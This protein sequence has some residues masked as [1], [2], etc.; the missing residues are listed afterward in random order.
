MLERQTSVQTIEVTVKVS[1]TNFEAPVINPHN[2]TVDELLVGFEWIH[3]SSELKSFQ[4][5]FG[6]R[7]LHL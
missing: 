2:Q 4:N 6:P 5:R 3:G 1:S 7:K